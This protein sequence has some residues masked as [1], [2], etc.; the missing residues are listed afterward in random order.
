MLLR[1]VRLLDQPAGVGQ[2]LLQ[3]GLSRTPLLL[4]ALLLRALADLGQLVAQLEELRAACLGL[5]LGIAEL[6]ARLVGLLARGVRLGLE[7]GDRLGRRAA[8]EPE[9]H[10]QYGG[11]HR[12]DECSS[13]HSSLLGGRGRVP[14]RPRER[15]P[16]LTN[17]LHR[18][19]RGAHGDQMVG[20]GPFSSSNTAFSNAARCSLP[21]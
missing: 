6:R 12:D 17:R 21:A 10:R 13:R 3:L 20:G 11:D 19:G 7:A 2:V 1:R 15:D 5:G 14:E 9:D 18:G 4:L 16:N 8:L